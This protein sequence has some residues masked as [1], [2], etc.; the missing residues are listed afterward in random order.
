MRSI[1][2]EHQDPFLDII[3]ENVRAPV[4][5]Y[6]LRVDE[7]PA[8]EIEELE[9]YPEGIVS[10]TMVAVE[11]LLVITKV[12][13]KHFPHR[14]R[15][16][17][18]S[19]TPLAPLRSPLSTFVS[20][21]LS[22]FLF[23]PLLPLS[24]SRTTDTLLSFSSSWV[25]VSIISSLPTRA[26]DSLLYSPLYFLPSTLQS[27]RLSFQ[28]IPHFLLTGCSHQGLTSKVSMLMLVC[29]ASAPQVPGRKGKVQPTLG[30]VARYLSRPQ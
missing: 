30:P 11:D 23:S 24:E 29:N 7:Q 15:D 25:F 5:R 4:S 14:G 27:R 26:T 13:R 8:E 10:P 2:G 3:P 21:Y 28:P 9:D 12:T 19:Q 20:S 6:K 1:D 17:P 16:P 22:W 18:R